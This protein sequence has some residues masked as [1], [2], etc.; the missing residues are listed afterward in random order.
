I[1]KIK[2]TFYGRF[3]FLFIEMG[4]DLYIISYM[5]YMFS[6]NPPEADC[7]K[8]EFNFVFLFK[9]KGRG[10]RGECPLS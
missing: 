6:F 7:S 8:K 4:L 2:P 10:G 5:M 3:Y 9:A 1:R